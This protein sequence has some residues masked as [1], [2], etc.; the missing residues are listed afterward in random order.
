MKVD[1][2]EDLKKIVGKKVYL[3]KRIAWNNNDYD[4]DTF[5][6]EVGSIIIGRKRYK[7]ELGLVEVF[8][9]PILKD[10]PWEVIGEVPI[11]FV[12]NTREEALDFIAEYE[13]QD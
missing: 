6:L 12:W 4:F 1:T 10:D 8:I 2:I 13:R 5:E 7:N 3:G 9:K 11:D